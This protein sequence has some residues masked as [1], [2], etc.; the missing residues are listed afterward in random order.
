MR[1]AWLLGGL[2]LCR[3]L[4][5]RA[6][7]AQDVPH[8]VVQLDAGGAVI[9]QPGLLTTS[10][11][12][13]G[14]QASLVSERQL[15]SA[16]A[17]FAVTPR[18]RFTQQA[19]ASLSYFGEPEHGALWEIGLA[20]SAFTQTDSAA[21]MSARFVAREHLLTRHGGVF[22]GGSVGATSGDDDFHRT[23]SVEA[24]MLHRFDLFGRDAL[25]GMLS[26]SWLEARAGGATAAPRFADVSVVASHEGRRVDLSAT[27]TTRFA[28]RRERP[29]SSGALGATVWPADRIGIVASVGRTLADP[30]RGLPPVRYA[31][32]A[33]R[34]RLGDARRSP[35]RAIRDADDA[36]PRLHVARGDDDRWIVTIDVRG[37]TRVEMMADFTAWEAV[38]LAASPGDAGRWTLVMDIPPGTHRVAIR[39]DGGEWLVPPNLPAVPDDFGGRVGLVTIP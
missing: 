24:G 8:P 23:V 6:A 9:S 21:A 12:T 36:R 18:R 15:A 20:A 17:L 10:V 3:Q 35:G 37:A 1:A 39:I 7:G 4:A 22:A 27:G 28:A 29:G 32:L 34:I 30:L 38:P 5:P 13:L 14:A 25:T 19:V 26:Y 31:T 16:S 2:L 33:L 11:A